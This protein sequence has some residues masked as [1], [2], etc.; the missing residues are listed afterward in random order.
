MPKYLG[1]NALKTEFQSGF[2][3]L[4]FPCNQFNLAEP[5]A[6]GTEI[7]DA[8]KYVRP[9]NG[10]VPN[11]QMFKK[12][13]VNGNNEIPLYTYLKKQCDPP[14]DTFAP[15]HRL[16]YEPLRVS[17]VRWNFE[18]FLVDKDGYPAF[19]FNSSAPMTDIDD[20]T[21]DL[22]KTLPQKRNADLEASKKAKVT[23][24]GKRTDEQ[25]RILTTP[26]A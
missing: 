10:F 1:A 7:L 24:L 23:L 18:V 26:L 4:G 15:R 11:F 14:S 13:D 25:K 22:M 21:R 19:R 17:D 5:E 3:V 16:Y 12:I 9:G 2:E 6:N 8:I 20:A